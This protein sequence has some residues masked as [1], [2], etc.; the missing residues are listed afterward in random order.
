MHRAKKALYNNL[1]FDGFVKMHNTL[2]KVPTRDRQV[3]LETGIQKT[4]ETPLDNSKAHGTI[5]MKKIRFE[6]TVVKVI[7]FYPKKTGLGR[8]LHTFILCDLYR[9]NVFGGET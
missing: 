1:N 6:F 7:T 3:W 2:L 5:G 9:I 4:N 8:T